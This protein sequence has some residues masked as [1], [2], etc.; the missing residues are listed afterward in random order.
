MLPQAD[1]PAKLIINKQLGQWGTQYDAS[2]DLARIDLK[3]EAADKA[4]DQLTMAISK[5]P[6]G[7]GTLKIMWEDA[8]VFNA[9]HRA[10]II[11]TGKIYD[12]KK[13]PLLFC[14]RHWIA[15]GR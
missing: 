2:Q 6:A 1:G 15:D 4:A 8:P 5:N 10:E 11:P 9:V 3:K 14:N 7:G 13:T 12:F